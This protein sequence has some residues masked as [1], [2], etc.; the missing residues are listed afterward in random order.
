MLV[1]SLFLPVIVFIVYFD[2]KKID[3]IFIYDIIINLMD[4]DV[5]KSEYFQN[6]KFGEY[7]NQVVIFYYCSEHEDIACFVSDNLDIDPEE[8]PS[9]LAKHCLSKRSCY[10]VPFGHVIF[11]KEPGKVIDEYINMKIPNRYFDVIQNDYL[12]SVCK[13]DETP[14]ELLTFINSNL[15]VKFAV[16]IS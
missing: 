2:V 3:N 7:S 9:V 6:N 5:F 1:S 15:L 14:Q 8:Y 12:V 10:F 16:K 13:F 11:D 4:N